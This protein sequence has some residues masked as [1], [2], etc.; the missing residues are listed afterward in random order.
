MKTLGRLSAVLAMATLAGTAFAQT[1]DAGAHHDGG[2]EHAEHH[3]SG[4]EHHDAGAEHHE[5]H[6][7]AAGTGTPAEAHHTPTHRPAHPSSGA[8]PAAH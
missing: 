1:P 8:P 5:G 4:S 3:E 7:H 6:D 2:A